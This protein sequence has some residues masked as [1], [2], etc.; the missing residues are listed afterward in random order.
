MRRKP[1]LTPLPG[2]HKIHSELL[3]EKVHITLVGAGGNGSQMLSGLARLHR[4]LLALGHPHGLH[5]ICYDPDQV[6]EANVG[7]QLYSPS[8]VGH[9]KAVLLIHRL[10]CFHGLDWQAIPLKYQGWQDGYGQ[11]RSDILITCV[12]S[13][14]ARR[15]I[16]HAISE[17]THGTPTY[18]LDMGNGEHD[19]Q[20]VL[21]QPRYSPEYE[22]HAHMRAACKLLTQR[23][24]R[25]ERKEP[26]PQRLPTVIDAFP[27][28]L[29]E[30]FVEEDRPSCSLAESL[31]T[32]GV[33]VNQQVVTWGLFLLETLF[34]KGEIRHHGYS[35]N[36]T[37]GIV[38]P[39]PVPPEI[40]PI[41]R[42]RGA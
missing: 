33:F 8:D 41:K 25:K 20:V 3:H 15:T 21:G 24:R 23:G 14:Q 6:S 13:A 36:M 12:D 32:Q 19:G 1:F 40:K 11:H 26:L 10:N 28:L 39:Y 38:V 35:I 17:R 31:A 27:D 37:D 16:Y 34:R 22:T 9:Y 2:V 42:G 7:R 29:E 4:S 18:W 5:V 30:G